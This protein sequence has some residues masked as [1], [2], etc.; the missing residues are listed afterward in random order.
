MVWYAGG[1]LDS[2]ALNSRR[3][4]IR[5]AMLREAPD[6]SAAAC[7]VR[8][9][10][11]ELGNPIPTARCHAQSDISR[12]PNFDVR[13]RTRVAAVSR[14]D[15]AD[16][17]ALRRGRGLFF[18][19]P[20]LLSTHDARWSLRLVLPNSSSYNA[21]AS[22]AACLSHTRIHHLQLDGVIRAGS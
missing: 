4:A 9:G 12:L 16:M 14:D 7:T 1:V 13:T 5:K 8:F 21:W 6:S 10:W 3:L 19:E 15:P 2:F 22:K 17:T 11:L 20:R 18:S